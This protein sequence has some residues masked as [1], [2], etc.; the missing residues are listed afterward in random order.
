MWGRPIIWHVVQAVRLASPATPALVVTSE[1]SSDDPLVA[2]LAGVGIPFHRG[3]LDDVYGRFRSCLRDHPCDWIMRICA[4][5]PLLSAPVIQ[6]IVRTT[7]AAEGESMPDMF[8]TTSP[9]SFPKGQNVEV[10][11]SS[12]FE[13]V[14]PSDLTSHDREH[15]TAYFHRQP[16]RFR[17]HNLESGDRS[18]ADISLVVDTVDDLHRL[19]AV[20]G[21]ELVSFGC[22]HLVAAPGQP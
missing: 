15:V 10:I 3:S 4:D 7:L 16:N 18:R 13:A 2:Y 20:G 21:D 22:H 11:R 17:I 14:D 12:T 9:R 19:E 5:S 8:T 1:Q 6:L